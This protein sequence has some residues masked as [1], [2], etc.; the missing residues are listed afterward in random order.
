MKEH[1]IMTTPLGTKIRDLRK[2]KG[3]TLD[4]LAELQIQ[5]GDVALTQ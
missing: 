1:A 2:Q 3:F 5:P 4:K